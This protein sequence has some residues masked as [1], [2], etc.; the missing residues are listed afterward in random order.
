MGIFLTGATMKTPWYITLAFGREKVISYWELSKS[1]FIILKS[2]ISQAIKISS[3]K[4]AAALKIVP[5]TI[6]VIS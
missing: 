6:T 1:P 5:F 2:F 4:A 3:E